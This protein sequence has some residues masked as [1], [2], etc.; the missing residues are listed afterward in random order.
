[1]KRFAAILSVLMV[2][3]GLGFATGASE[4]GGDTENVVLSQM[5]SQGWT[6]PVHEELSELFTEETGIAVD[7]QVTPADQHHDLL[8]TKL[9]AGEAPDIFWIQ[10]NPFAVKTELDPEKNCIDFTGEE[11]VDVLEPA[12]LPSVSYNGRVYGQMLWHGSVEFPILYNKTLFEELGLSTPDTYADFRGAA[13]AIAQEGIVPVYEHVPSGWHHVLH[14]MQI[15][16]SY[17]QANPDV[18]EQLNKNEI[19][20]SDVPGLLRAVTQ[21]KEF[22][23]LGYF[24][25]D[26]LSNTGSD[27]VA[28]LAERR[29]AMYA[30]GVT[31]P[32]QIAEDYPES[33]DEWGAFVIPFNDNQTFPGNPSGPAMFGYSQSPYQEQIREYFRWTTRIDNLQYLLD[34]HPE[35]TNIDLS[36]AAEAQIEQ[37]Y[38]PLEQQ[39]VDSLTDEAMSYTVMQSSV[40]Y[41]NEQW[42]D[43]GADLEA[44]FVGAMTPEEV[45]AAIDDRRERLA[46]AQSDPNWQ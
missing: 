3:V 11:W 15:G 45:V 12:R 17:V 4:E 23:D 37:H 20:V 44:M 34:N 14:I 35:W 22:A 38:N 19:T 21:L 16:G 5:V 10:S 40:K 1:M 36:P 27:V 29:A 33:T 28:Q 43:M 32:Q 18:Y 2:V 7:W 9:N 46:R 24:G 39:V 41:I 30:G 13:A 8:R 31:T 6:H 26:F 42:M 25:E